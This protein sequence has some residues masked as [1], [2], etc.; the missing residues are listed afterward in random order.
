MSAC[1]EIDRN[2][3]AWSTAKEGKKKLDTNRLHQR[4]EKPT[5][6][7]MNPSSHAP[8]DRTA[9]L[10]AAAAAARLLST[11]AWCW[12]CS[13]AGM[14]RSRGIGS[15]KRSCRSQCI[16]RSPPPPPPPPPP[17]SSQDWRRAWGA[18]PEHGEEE[19]SLATATGATRTL[20]L[21]AVCRGISQRVNTYHTCSKWNRHFLFRS[22][23]SPSLSLFAP[24]RLLSL[25]RFQ[26]C[27]DGLSS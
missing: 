7:T 3:H 2:I 25:D 4:S 9:T 6:K 14:H 10:A 13:I 21:A 5:A 11:Q 20:P 26:T 17:P 15:I 12:P 1:V 8:T 16:S 22:T 19:P 23:S 18:Y 27:D 24:L